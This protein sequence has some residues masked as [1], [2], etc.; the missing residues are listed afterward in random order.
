MAQENY[1]I[2]DDA[3]QGLFLRSEPVVNESTRIVVLPMGHEVKK[4][5]ESSVTPWWEVSTE[6]QGSD[7]TGFVNSR[8]LTRSEDFIPI[9]TV[10]RITSVHLRRN[11]AVTRRNEAWAFALNENGMPR[12]DP[13]DS[14]AEKVAALTRIVEFLDV[15]NNNFERYKP[16]P[17]GGS[18]YCNIYAYDYCYLAGVYLP[19]VWWDSEALIDLE[20]GRDVQPAYGQTVDELS[21]NSLFNWLR[22]YGSRFGWRRVVSIREMQDAANNG[23][24][25]VVSAHHRLTNSSG[26]ITAVVPETGA[27]RAVRQNGAVVQPLQS[28]AGRVNR[29]YQTN[30]WWV[31]RAPDFREHG[32]WINNA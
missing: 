7:L 1:R 32:F 23:Q 29:K 9:D 6:L 27:N 17:N 14:P 28:Q 31:D 20:A 10:S 26:H 21:A 24:V 2:N 5:S 19:R 15:A 16:V 3:P 11:A 30:L 25:V 4:L 12:R 22:Q 8:F 13:N 18:T